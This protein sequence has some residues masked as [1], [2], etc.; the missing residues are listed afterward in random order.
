MSNRRST[1]VACISGMLVARGVAADPCVDAQGPAEFV[2]AVRARGLVVEGRC[3]SLA[4]LAPDDAQAWRLTLT[5]VRGVR[6]DLPVPAIAAAVELTVAWFA[7]EIETTAVDPDPA[8]SDAPITEVR[9]PSPRAPVA[10]PAPV[11]ASSTVTAGRWTAESVIGLD[12]TLDRR[13]A[14][15]GGPRFRI[16]WGPLM[17]TAAYWWTPAA[18]AD[19]LEV[20]RSRTEL[21]AGGQWAFGAVRLRGELGAV[22]RTASPT[23]ASIGRGA[24]RFTVLGVG[25]AVAW[26]GR[27]GVITGCVELAGRS[28]LGDPGYTYGLRS[29]LRDRPVGYLGLGIGLVVR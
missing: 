26:C 16:G 20:S 10:D 13:G 22:I 28:D 12:L 15:W 23:G 6:L 11:P 3:P 9:D 29:E 7:R 8:P 1:V 4:V 21:G 18:T 24:E 27:A 17:V 5:D 19:E 14:A 2:E 25:L